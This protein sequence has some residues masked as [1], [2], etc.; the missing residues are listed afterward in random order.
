MA[1][2]YSLVG[3]ICCHQSMGTWALSASLTTVSNPVLSS[4]VQAFVL[5]LVFSS[6]GMDLKVELLSHRL[7]LNLTF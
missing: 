5:T 4:H 3:T 7:T 6:P 1:E 2:K